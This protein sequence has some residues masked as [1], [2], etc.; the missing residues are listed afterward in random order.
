MLNRYTQH[1]NINHAC[2][3]LEADSQELPLIHQLFHA[4]RDAE[5]APESNRN[6]RSRVGL[7]NLRRV[8]T[9]EVAAVQDSL[10]HLSMPQRPEEPRGPM[11]SS[12]QSPH[13]R[14][15]RQDPGYAGASF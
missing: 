11:L 10:S 9:T 3:K 7:A 8:Q 13:P 6:R 2:C 15:Y 14:A 12:R 5:D 4:A 1:T